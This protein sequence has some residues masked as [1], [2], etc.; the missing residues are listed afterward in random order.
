MPSYNLEEA[1]AISEELPNRCAVKLMFTENGVGETLLVI[2]DDQEA[3]TT[4]Y[5]G[6]LSQKPKMLKGV[7]IGDPIQFTIMNV[8]EIIE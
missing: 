4:T 1:N 8:F 2:V 3:G 5:Y 7:G 6:T